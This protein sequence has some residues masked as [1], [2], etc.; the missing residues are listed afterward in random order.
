VPAEKAEAIPEAVLAKASVD[1]KYRKLLRRIKVE[2]DKQAYGEFNDYGRYTATSYAGY[3]DLPAG[4]WVYVYP[5]W[6]IWGELKD[7]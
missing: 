5:H 2:D 1:G 7:K 4:Y 3:N 6:Y